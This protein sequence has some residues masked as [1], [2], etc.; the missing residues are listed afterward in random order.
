MLIMLK[1]GLLGFLGA[2]AGGGLGP[3]LI[4]L[5]AGDWGLFPILFPVYG[6]RGLVAGAVLLSVMAG[7]IPALFAAAQDPADIL[8]EE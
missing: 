7:W 1:V 3:F 8:R 4:A 5:K 2:L 6:L